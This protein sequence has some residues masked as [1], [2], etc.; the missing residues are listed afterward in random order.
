MLSGAD[1][2][3]EVPVQLLAKL[4]PDLIKVIKD[5]VFCQKHG[6]QCKRIQYNIVGL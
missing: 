1:N 3:S 2:W 6:I 4:L 5:T